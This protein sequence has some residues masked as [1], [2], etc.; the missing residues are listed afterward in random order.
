MN[1]QKKYRVLLTKLT[2]YY[3][4]VEAE[5]DDDARLKV[6]N[7][8]DNGTIMPVVDDEFTSDYDVMEAIELDNE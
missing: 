7:D 8:I 3:V 6:Q 5:H 4:E 2:S 1:E